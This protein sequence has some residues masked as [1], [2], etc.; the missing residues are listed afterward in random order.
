MHPELINDSLVRCFKD[1]V[2]YKKGS[3]IKE[4]VKLR[5]NKSELGGD[6]ECSLEL[7]RTLNVLEASVS[8]KSIYPVNLDQFYML[9]GPVSPA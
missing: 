3:E 9:M 6:L 4:L 7:E 1:F 8:D 2:V 5:R